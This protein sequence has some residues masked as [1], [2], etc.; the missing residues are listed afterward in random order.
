MPYYSNTITGHKL[1]FMK[2]FLFSILGFIL[3]LKFMRNYQRSV[4]PPMT[5]Y[6]KGTS[7]ED[8]RNTQ[9][10]VNLGV[11]H[12][13]MNSK[14]HR[15]DKHTSNEL[16]LFWEPKFWFG[17]WIGNQLDTS[18]V[19][20]KCPVSTCVL[21]KNRLTLHKADAVVFRQWSLNECKRKTKRGQVWIVFEHEPPTRFFFRELKTHCNFNLFNW[22]MSYRRDTDFTLNYGLF[23][24]ASYPYDKR[25]LHTTFKSKTKTAVAF[26]SHCRDQ[27][28]RLQYI[29]KLRS[30]GIDVDV[31][32]SCGNLSCHS[33]LG[34]MANKKAVWN[35]SM[36]FE[37]QRDCFG[38]LDSEYKFYLSF[39]NSLC[40][41]YVTEKSLHLVLRHDILPIIRDGSNR[42]LFHPPNSYLDTKDFISV[43]ALA[44][45][46]KLL[47]HNFA[48]YERY[49]HWKKYFSVENISAVLQKN[50][51][52][53]CKRLN[54]QRKYQRV[55]RNMVASFRSRNPISPVCHAPTDS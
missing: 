27:S 7:A 10:K 32:G 33:G 45:Y 46:I 52:E 31:Y 25:A 1:T 43:K 39:E 9:I 49:F 53:I 30:H 5:V 14:T 16:I 51:C 17:D 11:K 38:V 15:N 4:A 44:D 40:E 19:F 12:D 37:M 24:N 8:K 23:S 36:N 42:S 6:L 21:T 3:S 18:D 28:N 20:K 13:V 26:I 2:I 47:S 50:L 54:D 34:I 41:D 22:T 29:Q 55:N 48:A 35:V